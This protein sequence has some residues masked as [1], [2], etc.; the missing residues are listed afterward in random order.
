MVE[1]DLKNVQNISLEIL[2]T[3]SD[4]CE[5]KG[6]NYYLMYGTLLGAIRHEGFIPWDD[7]LDIMMPRNDYE[8]LLRY[9][10]SHK[11]EYP[12]L[13]IFNPQTCK[14]YPYMIT[15]ISNN[16]YKI[17]TEN[18]KDY[19]L[20]VFI[21]IYPFDGLGNNSLIATIHGLRGDLLSSLCFQSTREYFTLANTES[22][23]KKSAKYPI[24]LLSKLL[25]TKVLMNKLEK[26]SHKY[27]YK[28]SNFVGCVT[29]LSGGKKDIFQ[30]KYFTKT[31]KKKFEN[32]Y[33]NVPNGYEIILKQIYGNYHELPPMNQ[34]VG[35]HFYKIYKK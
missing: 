10:Q 23:L 33:F 29:W 9:L 15:R 4:I 8:R 3:I 26:L 27:D 13:D 1:L 30:K 2:K 6:F 22:F 20:G 19:G 24:F 21:D 34:R 35:H 31:I 16:K 18:E 28:T 17:V 7:D 5:K 14:D 11:Q 12:D 25:G 32:Y